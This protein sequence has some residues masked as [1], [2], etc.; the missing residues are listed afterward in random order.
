MRWLTLISIGYHFFS[1]APS[2]KTLIRHDGL[3][4][5]RILQLCFKGQYHKSEDHHNDYISWS[6]AGFKKIMIPWTTAMDEFDS[7]RIEFPYKTNHTEIIGSLRYSVRDTQH[8]AVFL[9]TDYQDEYRGLGRTNGGVLGVVDFM[10][11]HKRWKLRSLTPGVV[12]EGTFSK[13]HE[14]QEV[15][16][17]PQNQVFFLL[18]GGNANAAGHWY[19]FYDQHIFYF[20][21]DTCRLLLYDPHAH[22]ET[23]EDALSH[24]STS[25]QIGNFIEITTK[26]HIYEDDLH[27]EYPFSNAEWWPKIEEFG[28]DTMPFDFLVHRQYSVQKGILYKHATQFE[29]Q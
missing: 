25:I 4:T 20:E 14:P 11:I 16:V 10:R 2:A 21:G 12:L 1:C 22:L 19:N 8:C 18:K 9:S 5:M 7:I 27:Q 17:T 26:G 29:R 28:K 6:G 23:I 24:W 13:A 3:D 15:V